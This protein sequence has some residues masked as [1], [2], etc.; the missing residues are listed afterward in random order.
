MMFDRL[1]ILNIF[2]AWIFSTYNGLL[3][4]NP[5]VSQGALAVWN[6]Q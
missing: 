2:S 5:I 6:T 4:C 1:G 3:G